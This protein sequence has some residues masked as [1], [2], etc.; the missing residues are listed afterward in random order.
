M[1]AGNWVSLWSCL[2]RG[3][4]TLHVS[5]TYPRAQGPVGLKEKNKK[6]SR[7]SPVSFLCLPDFNV[8]LLS[9]LNKSSHDEFYL[10]S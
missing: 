10:S 5:G 7:V 6:E 2:Q 1:D 9:L 3:T 8:C 4:I